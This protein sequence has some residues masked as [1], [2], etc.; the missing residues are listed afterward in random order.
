[1]SQRVWNDERIMNVLFAA[2]AAV[3]YCWSTAELTFAFPSEPQGQAESH[4]IRP[5]ATG[6][7]LYMFDGGVGESEKVGTK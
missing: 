1:M 6:N 5:S 7:V 3:M 4:D 2:F